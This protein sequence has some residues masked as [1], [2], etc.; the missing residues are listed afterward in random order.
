MA[1]GQPTEDRIRIAATEVLGR[2]PNA[3]LAAITRAAGVSRATFYR[4]FESRG[5]LLAALDIE[6][7]PDSRQRILAAAVD[8][9]GRDGLRGMSMEE[10]ASAAGVS[11]ASVYRLFP[12]KA[13]LFD[14]LLVEHSPF[15]ALEA[16][17]ERMSDQP[18][19]AVLPELAHTIAAVAGPRIG[20]LRSIFF[21]VTSQSE[22][23][24][25]GAEPRLR[26]MLEAVGGYLAAQMAAGRLRPMPPVLAAQ[27]LLGPIVFHLITR[28]ELERLGAPIGSLDES[29]DE[30]AHAAVRALAMPDEGSSNRR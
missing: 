13:A 25:E 18:P 6:P 14:A 24:L 22:D 2:D 11:R 19:T 29:I 21:E 30:L 12:G 4:H 3:S 10:L 17:L 16:V 20:I 9:I 1:A 27:A 28:A 5:E 26:H 8:L 7:D 23:A 15:A